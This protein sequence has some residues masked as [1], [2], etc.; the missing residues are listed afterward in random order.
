MEGSETERKKEKN[1]ES[2][3]NK[4]ICMFSLD[5]IVPYDVIPET[6]IPNIWLWPMCVCV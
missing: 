1:S 3:H 4:L 2:A 5:Y 6:E